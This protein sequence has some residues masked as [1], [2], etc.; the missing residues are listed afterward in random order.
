MKKIFFL[1][2][3]MS[4]ISVRV[5]AQTYEVLD[6]GYPYPRLEG[7]SLARDAR[8]LLRQQDNVFESTWKNDNVT[9]FPILTTG[10]GL[11]E[12]SASHSTVTFQRFIPDL[13]IPILSSPPRIYMLER[14]FLRDQLFQ[15]IHDLRTLH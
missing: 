13:G 9:V 14:G 5:K 4:V 2:A 15:S 10:Q 1:F 8:P 3:L 7:E 11:F 6:L 12:L